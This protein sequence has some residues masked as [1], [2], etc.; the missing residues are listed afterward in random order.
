MTIIC[1][2]LDLCIDHHGWMC[3][4]TCMKYTY[5]ILIYVYSYI[6]IYSHSYK[7]I[8]HPIYA[9]IDAFTFI[10]VTLCWRISPCRITT[11]PPFGPIL[12]SSVS[13]RPSIGKPGSDSTAV[14]DDAWHHARRGRHFLTTKPRKDANPIQFHEN[15]IF[16]FQ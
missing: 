3:V 15:G 10:Y 5:T 16:T 14:R 13:S 6:Y 4:C 8:L 9:F 7:I 2:T 11:C 12:G 1:I